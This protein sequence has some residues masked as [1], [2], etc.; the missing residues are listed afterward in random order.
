[1]LGSLVWN[2]KCF[3]LGQKEVDEVHVCISSR[4]SQSPHKYK[5]QHINGCR[6]LMLP[7]IASQGQTSGKCSKHRELFTRHQAQQND[8]A[9]NP[10]RMND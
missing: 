4:H 9:S 6:L 1:M 10:S 8:R 5:V 2:W 3:E 7:E